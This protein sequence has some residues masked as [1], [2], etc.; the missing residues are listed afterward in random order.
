MF[1]V[2]RDLFAELHGRRVQSRLVV[3]EHL[4]YLGVS[5]FSASVSAVTVF[6][7]FASA[8]FTSAM[9][10]ASPFRSVLH[11]FDATRA[12]SA[13]F[14]HAAFATLNSCAFHTAYPPNPPP[15]NT[16]TAT[17]AIAGTSYFGR[18]PWMYGVMPYD[19]GTEACRLIDCRESPL[20]HNRWFF[21]YPQVGLPG[22]H[23]SRDRPKILLACHERMGE[24][25][26]KATWRVSVPTVAT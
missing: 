21:P 2:P 5:A 18:T 22:E 19:E 15:A 8:G 9:P 12:E 25:R 16:S 7:S 13:A 24:E 6:A 14:A 3:G 4:S 10:A 20:F 23:D 26:V 17:D 1:R 11:S